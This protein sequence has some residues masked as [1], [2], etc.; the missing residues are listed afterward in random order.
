MR[1]QVIGRRLGQ[2]AQRGR[3][4]GRGA[5]QAVARGAVTLAA[6]AIAYSLFLLGLIALYGLWFTLLYLWFVL[7][8]RAI[9][10][11]PVMGDMLA[12]GW[13]LLAVF[14]LIFLIARTWWPRES[15][16]PD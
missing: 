9:G 2:A 6:T 14:G 16:A 11:L 3:A 8:P 5:G 15:D 1:R 13:P 10:R 4:E 7:L 12:T